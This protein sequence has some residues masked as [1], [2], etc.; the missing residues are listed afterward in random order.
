MKTREEITSL[1]DAEKH[2][3]KITVHCPSL[4]ENM[5]PAPKLFNQKC[6]NNLD[7]N[8]HKCDHFVGFVPSEDGTVFSYMSF[9]GYCMKL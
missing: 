9:D 6:P 7:G 1:E 3:H 5:C 4:D 2:C 8:C